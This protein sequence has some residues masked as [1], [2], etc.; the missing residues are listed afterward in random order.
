MQSTDVSAEDFQMAAV[1]QHGTR[2]HRYLNC[3]KQKNP[4]MK[5]TEPTA[6]FLFMLRGTREQLS[7]EFQDKYQG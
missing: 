7:T 1:P 4:I 3:V 5:L 6:V 2:N